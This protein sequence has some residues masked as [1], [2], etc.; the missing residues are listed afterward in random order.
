ME[1]AIRIV[2]GNFDANPRFA[3]DDEIVE[4]VIIFDV[5]DD[6]ERIRIFQPVE[7]FAAFAAPIRVV[8]DRV[9]LPN[10]RVNAEPEQKHLQQRHRQREKKCPRIAAD[11]Q[12]FLIKDRPESAEYVKHAPPPK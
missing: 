9:D 5:S 10:V 2:D 4:V 3:R 11:V 1:E 8:D 6:V 12:H 7:E